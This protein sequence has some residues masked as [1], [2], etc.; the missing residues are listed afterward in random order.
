MLFPLS[1][2]VL[3]KT[4]TSGVV[5]CTCAPTQFGSVVIVVVGGRLPDDAVAYITVKL[6]KSVPVALS[7]TCMLY[8]SGEVPSD[9]A[10]SRDVTIAGA[11][12]SRVSINN[13]D[14]PAEVLITEPL[15]DGALV[16]FRCH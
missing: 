11:A 5:S 2:T 1:C 3:A 7:E 15:T 9:V 4:A 8:V 16:G 6:F 12:G 10:T 13:F 14:A